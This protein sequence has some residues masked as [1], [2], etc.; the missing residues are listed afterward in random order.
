VVRHDD[1]A[2]ARMQCPSVLAL[3]CA[4]NLLA[5]AAYPQFQCDRGDQMVVAPAPSTP[6]RFSKST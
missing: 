3:L 1:R 4:C 2:D 6:T 5:A